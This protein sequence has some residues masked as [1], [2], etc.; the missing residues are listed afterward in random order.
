MKG[1]QAKALARRGAIVD[2][3]R[4]LLEFLNGV[5][6][7]ARTTM[8]DFMASDRVRSEVS[9]VVKNVEL[10]EGTWDGESY[11]LAGRIKL[12]E[13]RAVVAANRAPDPVGAAAVQE[14]KKNQPKKT[15]KYTGLV[16]DARHLPL[17][18]AMTF[19]V[20]DEAG[21][22][23]YG[24]EFV[25]WQDYLQSGLCSYYHNI[26]YARGE[27]HVAPNPIVTKATRL[28]SGN[29]DIVIPNGD[30]AK[31]RGSV[32]DFRRECKVVVVSK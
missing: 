1:A 27:A 18:P 2:L 25:N 9:G 11:T 31:A 12:P 26:G 4:N 10:L 20:F 16:I 14:E 17:V 29:V 19:S 13:L 24:M 23:V 15:V 30:A 5:Q 3:Q 32:Y 7:D 28:T 6:V 22:A 21:R 8:E